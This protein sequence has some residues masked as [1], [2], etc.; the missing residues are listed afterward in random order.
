MPC[1]ANSPR[2]SWWNDLTCTH[3]LCIHYIPQ[4][5]NSPG[6][7][8]LN[9]VVDDD[10]AWN[11]GGMSESGSNWNHFYCIYQYDNGD[12]N[13]NEGEDQENQASDAGT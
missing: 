6:E 10:D 7:G 2:V 9:Y 13:C 8:K 5:R 11:V 3:T 4:L 1:I 12:G